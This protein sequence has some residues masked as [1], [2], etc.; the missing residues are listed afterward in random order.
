MRQVAVTEGDKV[1]AEMTFGFAVNGYGV[2]DLVAAMDK[3]SAAAASALGAEYETLYTVAPELRKGGERHESLRYGARIELGLR[4]FLEA[5]GFKGFTDTFEDLHGL[6][7]LPGLAPQRL[8]ADG[9]GFAGEG[10]WKTARWC[11]R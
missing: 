2:G 9:Y 6:K 7:Q 4:A 5:G 10:D 11:A 3:V 8:M 1:S